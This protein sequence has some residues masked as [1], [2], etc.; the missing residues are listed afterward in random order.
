MKPHQLPNKKQLYNLI[1]RRKRKLYADTTGTQGELIDF[2]IPRT[3]ALVPGD[4]SV[5]VPLYEVNDTH[6]FVAMTTRSLMGKL[7]CADI[8]CVDTTF[9]LNYQ[10]FPVGVLRNSTPSC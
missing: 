6:T 10:E 2:C 4:K 8:L 1:A 9:K 3:I 7:L 5:I